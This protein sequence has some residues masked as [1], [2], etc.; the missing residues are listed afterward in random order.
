MVGFGTIHRASAAPQAAA[1]QLKRQFVRQR[2]DQVGITEFVQSLPPVARRAFV[3]TWGAAFIVVIFGLVPGW[4]A[5]VNHELGWPQWRTTAGQAIGVMLFIGGLS[6]A[7]YCSRLFARIGKGTPVPIA[8]PTELVISGLYRFT[9]NPI[10]VAQVTIL[11]SYFW[12]SGELA[13]LLYSG[14]WALLVQGF[15]V[16]V[17]EPDLRNRFGEDYLEYTREVPRWVSV[18]ARRRKRAA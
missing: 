17:E 12:Y 14:V 1:P 15:I 9:R 13:L 11:L 18:P 8:P 2:D 5:E 3:A 10:Y 7:A 16:W 6:L 4:V